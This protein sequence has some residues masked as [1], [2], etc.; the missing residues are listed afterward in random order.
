MS[1]QMT[2][3]AMERPETR[4]K[5]TREIRYSDNSISKREREFNKAEEATLLKREEHMAEA[6]KQLR[7][8][9]SD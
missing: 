6:I 7:K 1:H 5:K 2:E 8:L 4:V 9:L 3:N